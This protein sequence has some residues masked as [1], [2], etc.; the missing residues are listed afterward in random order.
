MRTKFVK[1]FFSQSYIDKLYVRFF[2]IPSERD[3]LYFHSYWRS[4]AYSYNCSVKMRDN[5]DS[6]LF[7]AHGLNELY[8]PELFHDS[9]IGRSL[10][11]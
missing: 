10:S 1:L 3:K 7:Q 8:H 11:Y 5:T 4:L 2:L 6:K 9:Y